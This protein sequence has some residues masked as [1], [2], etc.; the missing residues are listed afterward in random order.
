MPGPGS[1]GTLAADDD[2]GPGQ[3][4]TESAGVT[5]EQELRLLRRYEPIVRFNRGEL[6]L[7][8][9]IDGYLAHAAL[10]RRVGKSVEQLAAPGALDPDKLAA[11][12]RAHHGE[13]LYLQFVDQPLGPRAYRKWRKRPDREKFTPS[14]RFVAVGLA[15]RLI[16]SVLR[17]TLLLR[18]KVPRG[19]AA[20]AH[21][22]AS[23]AETAGQCHYYGHVSRDGGYVVLQY[24]YFYPMNDWRSTFGGVNDHEADWEQVTIFLAEHADADLTDDAGTDGAGTD[25]GAAAYKGA[26][27]NGRI[28]VT[29]PAWVA[30]SSHDET[31]DDLRRRWDDPDMERVGDH[32]VVYA[33]AGSHSGAY[34]KGEY[35]ITIAPPLPAEVNRIAMKIARIIPWSEP[36][37]SVIRIPYIDYRRGDGASV[38]PGQERKWTAVRIGDD[39]PW[40]VA[41]RGL[42]GLDTKDPFGGER[43]PAGPRYERHQAVRASWGQPVA[44]AAL[45]KEAPTDEEAEMRLRVRSAALREQLARV[46]HEV[47]AARAELRGAR[48]VDRANGLPPRQPSQAVGSLGDRV[49]DLRRRQAALRGDVEVAGRGLAGPI[50]RDDVHGH[51]HHRAIPN[52]DTSARHGR[53]RRLWTAASASI[54]YAVLGLILLDT[55]SG[56]LEPIFFAVGVMLVI[57]AAMRRRL[58]ALL[59]TAAIIFFAVS[60]GWAVASIVVGNLRAGVGVLLLLAALY[61]AGQTAREWLRMR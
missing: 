15:A 31:G 54:L 21:L 56:V 29:T 44:W 3:V 58:L 6:F 18:G 27:A 53:V 39:T 36:S 51:L 38:G 19:Y 37:S 55:R 9:A 40:V 61:M 8:C 10:Y 16:D 49:E 1:V 28:G 47:D 4:V 46:D 59:A 32:P 20:A 26:Y 11:F 5:A 43:A 22:K 24:W 35:L 60:L 30:F 33:G 2:G 48:A 17:M 25:G 14:S 23:S 52:V 57:E 7:P 42:W 34:L 45:D 12:G 50:P 41:Y 13:A